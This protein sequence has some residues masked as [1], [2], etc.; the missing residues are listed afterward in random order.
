MAAP[1]LSSKTFLAHLAVPCLIFDTHYLEDVSLSLHVSLFLKSQL[2]FFFGGGG[3]TFGIMNL[4]SFLFSK[5]HVWNGE[6]REET[7]FICRVYLLH[8]PDFSDASLHW[9]IQK[10]WA[11]LVVPQPSSQSIK[12]KVVFFCLLFFLPTRART[13]A[14]VVF[15]WFKKHVVLTVQLGYKDS[16]SLSSVWVWEQQR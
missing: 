13:V 2:S 12:K 15:T 14:L 9:K 6:R 3:V 16:L 8:F 7:N 11:Q 10:A 4:F 5:E 1:Y